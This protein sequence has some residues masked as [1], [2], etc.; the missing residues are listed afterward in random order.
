VVVI[1][2]ENIES[3]RTKTEP[4]S[5]NTRNQSKDELPI[6]QQKLQVMMEIA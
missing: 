1:R 5:K 6:S 4:R 2:Y 3:K